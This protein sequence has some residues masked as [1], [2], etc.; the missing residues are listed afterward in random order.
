M[1]SNSNIWSIILLVG[2]LYGKGREMRTI[3]FGA[4]GQDGSYLSEHLLEKGH[5]V[6]GVAR[7]TSTNSTERLINALAHPLFSLLPGDI[8]DFGSVLHIIQEYSADW[9]INLAAQSH[10]GT[11]FEQACSSMDI[12]AKGCINILEA[13]RQT[14]AV[15]YGIMP[16]T[17][18]T[19]YHYQGTDE[20]KKN[21]LKGYYGCL[22]SV[23]V[24]QASSSEMFGTATSIRPSSSSN[25]KEAGFT[26][27]QDEFTKFEPQS[28]YAVAKVAAHNFCRLY[29]EAY[30]MDI[31]CGIL[32]NHESERRGEEFV[33][34]KITKWLGQ[35]CVWNNPILELGQIWNLPVQDET[36]M[37]YNS[38][39]DDCG[40]PKL[41]LGNLDVSRDWGHA[42]DYVKAMTLIMEA[43]HADDWVVSTGQ[44]HT[45]KEFLE[46]A[47]ELA[48]LGCWKDY[49]VIDDKL[50]RP[51]E[52]PF[53][54][55][56]SSKIRE[57]LGWQPEISF[58][59]L[60]KRM[61][62]HDIN[63]Y[64]VSSEYGSVSS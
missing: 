43:A 26:I 47:F 10:V 60:V 46:M 13:V 6:I 31:R 18:N 27:F 8:T 59:Q 2:S 49:V 41:R 25:P 61:V 3:I 15:R 44:T 14:Q 50:K 11:S 56:D 38:L 48:G 39:Y 32:F 36:N 40:F 28:P 22:P 51:A 34:R 53:L 62:D 63:K 20:D 17:E 30:N 33:T 12:T 52:V 21:G 64:A 24:Y 19:T 1:V 7:R 58:S 42:K 37:L 23:K 29:R 9:I 57:Q 45:I 54:K 5:E 35:F 55:G 4:S 16:G